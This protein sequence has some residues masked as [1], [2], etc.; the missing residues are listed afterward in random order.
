MLSL[1]VPNI[2]T[3]VA[4]KKQNH[5]DVISKSKAIFLH[6]PFALL[7]VFVEYTNGVGFN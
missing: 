3:R 2:A 7:A 1:K 5:V 6:N 4:S